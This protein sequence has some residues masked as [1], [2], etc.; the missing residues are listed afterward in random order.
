M[1]I[2]KKDLF[3]CCFRRIH[4][5]FSEEPLRVL[6]TG[7]HPTSLLSRCFWSFYQLFL[8]FVGF[9][10]SLFIT[11]FNLY[12]GLFI[13][14]LIFHV[15]G[16]P[17]WPLRFINAYNSCELWTTFSCFH[18]RTILMTYQPKFQIWGGSLMRNCL[19]I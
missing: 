9:H 7:R 5:G 2:E 12:L 13:S 15:T 1:K 14:R 10:L 18:L 17:P 4:Y 8:Y 6:L 3:C 16:S 19:V 11:G